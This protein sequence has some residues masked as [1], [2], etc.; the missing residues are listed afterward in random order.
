MG[1]DWGRGRGRGF[2]KSIASR[3]FG[4][5][6]GVMLFAGGMVG[7]FLWEQMKLTRQFRMVSERDLPLANCGSRLDAAG[8][9]RR[10][11]FERWFG[12]LDGGLGNGLDGLVGEATAEYELAEKEIGE[13]MLEARRL[14]GLGRADDW[15]REELAKIGQLVEEIGEVSPVMGERYREIL[16]MEGEGKHK[17]A[18]ALLMGMRDLQRVLRG[19]RDELQRRT[20]DLT[21]AALLEVLAR[22][23]RTMGWAL[24]GMAV[25]V[26]VGIWFAGRESRRI[27]RPLRE[28]IVA[29]EEVRGGRL[30]VDLRLGGRDEVGELTEVF[31]YFVGELR[32]KEALRVTFG[33]YLDP[34]ILERLILG[35]EVREFEGGRDVMTVSFGDL[36][37]FTQ[38][39]ERLSP[40]AMVRILNRHFGLQAEVIQGELGVV[41]KFLGDAVMAF[42]GPPF[43]LAGEHA[44]RGC[45]A[46]LRQVK[47][48]EF[49]GEELGGL[50]GLKGK[51]L[52]LDLRVGL[53]TGEVMMGNIGSENTRSYTVI[54]DTVNL[55][56]RLEGLNRVYGTKILMNGVARRNAGEGFVTREIDLIRVKGKEEAVEVYEL[57]GEVGE[58]GE[59]KLKLCEVFAVGLA[60]YRAGEWREAEEGFLECLRLD[61]EDGPSRV[62]L[63]RL[64]VLRE[65][66]E[67]E[68][69]EGIWRFEAK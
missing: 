60:A 37:G 25:V 46:A 2:F 68:V 56:S 65:R 52:G 22:E 41:D 6:V 59:E 63:E 17:E 54:G 42:W 10:V 36:V 19:Q 69:W 3:I 24:G 32:A 39:S 66:W 29:L 44:E 5:A 18:V 40:P 13:Q 35:P 20:A 47:A 8:L 21:T 58:V 7:I 61:G 31:G 12:A 28:L 45:R 62:F 15:R 34:R 55:A 26:G 43:V 9:R 33:K 64:V 4:L 11:A 16:E 30:E 50:S 14:I 27:V 48:L 38:L 53:A 1:M 51:V 57:V 67:G 49:F 23:R